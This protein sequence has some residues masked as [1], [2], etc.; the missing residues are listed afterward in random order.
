[1]SIKLLQWNIWYKEKAENILA[2]IKSHDP[3]IVC[4]Q[5]LTIGGVFNPDIKDTAEYLKTELNYNL[6]FHSA[7][8]WEEDK[9]SSIGNGILSRFPIMRN[10]FRYLQEP[11]EVIRT[12]ADEGRVYIESD[13]NLGS[14]IL[15]VGTVHLSYTHRFE[16]A[17]GK[18]IE[19]DNLIKILKKKKSNYIVTGDFNALP[20]SYTVKGMQKYLKP[21]G[22]KDSLKTWTTKQF[23]YEGFSEDKLNW[24]LD[25]VFATKD[26]EVISSE[27][28]KT[29]FSDHLPI[30]ITIEVR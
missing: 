26:V 22:P 3:D 9:V 10:T 17:P 24:R 19:A 18:K 16:I 12:Y 27:I 15:T 28:I 2:L 29:D 30:L 20:D 25:Y 7:N 1:M 13:L 8:E 23:S 4:L 5:E 21:C 14:T 11:K 6:Y